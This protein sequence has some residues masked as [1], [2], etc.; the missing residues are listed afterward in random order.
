MA[1][2]ANRTSGAD[3]NRYAA[4]L[5]GVNVGGI[6]IKSADLRKVFEELGLREVR[7]V[8]ASGNVVF[9]STSTDAAALKRTIESALRTAFDYDAWIVLLPVDEVREILA[10]YPFDPERADWQ[11]YIMFASDTAV[12]DE[13]NELAPQLDPDRERIQLGRGV[14]YWEVQRGHTL[15]SV[16]GKASSKKKYKSTT[17]TRNVRTVQKVVA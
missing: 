14:L 16:F 13:L 3:G 17:T 4:F 8:L 9:E 15:D 6:T 5:R 1:A 10:A 7:T 11:P 12:L 2:K